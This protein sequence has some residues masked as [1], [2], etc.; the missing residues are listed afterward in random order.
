MEISLAALLIR[1]EHVW[2]PKSTFG[3]KSQRFP[4]RAA[5]HVE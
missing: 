3:W 4:F 1:V 5:R 2:T